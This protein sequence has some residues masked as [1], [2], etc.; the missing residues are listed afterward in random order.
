[1][2]TALVIF[3]LLQAKP[4]WSF[5]E[6]KTHLTISWSANFSKASFGITTLISHRCS[7]KCLNRKRKT[8]GISSRL[9]RKWSRS[10]TLK[11]LK[12]LSLMKITQFHSTVSRRI[13]FTGNSLK[14]TI[15]LHKISQSHGKRS[16]T[17]EPLRHKPNPFKSKL[18]RSTNKNITTV[19]LT[20]H[21]LDTSKMNQSLQKYF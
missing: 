6:A 5:W 2:S 11:P 9:R 17:Q 19:I 4:F 18:L 7:R 8:G 14:A 21:K 10:K 3:V 15:Y 1:M 13:Q 16:K 20:L 12:I